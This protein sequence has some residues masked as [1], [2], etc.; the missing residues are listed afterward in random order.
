MW[1]GASVCGVSYE[2][3]P[4]FRRLVRQ[5]R[6]YEDLFWHG[7]PRDF[8]GQNILLAFISNEL[9]A[10]CKIVYDHSGPQMNNGIWTVYFC[11]L[12]VGVLEFVSFRMVYVQSVMY[13]VYNKQIYWKQIHNPCRKAHADEGVTVNR[14]MALD[15]F[16]TMFWLKAFDLRYRNSI[17]LFVVCL[18]LL[19]GSGGVV[20]YTNQT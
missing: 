3:T 16:R 5:A 18:L 1:H 11:Y 13:L 14:G 8:T 19:G 20:L 2:G 10:F 9:K 15:K 17:T 4:P 7:F 12:H 6:G